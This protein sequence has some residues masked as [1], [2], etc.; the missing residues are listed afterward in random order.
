MGPV[1]LMLHHM[2]ALGWTL[3]DRL[4][5]T[6]RLGTTMHLTKGEDQLFDHLLREDLRRMIWARDVAVR[7]RG[8]LREIAGT[9][10]DYTSTVQMMCA[11]K[12]KGGTVPDGQENRDSFQLSPKQRVCTRSILGG[13][14]PTGERLFKAGLR[15][16]ALCLFC[17]TGQR[18]TT[19]HLWWECKDTEEC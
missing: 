2:K 3:S 7:N 13:A 16:T 17:L 5:I 8:D 1:A 9:N 14:V 19:K 18:E 6:R 12:K 10:I 11:K 15:K 4:A